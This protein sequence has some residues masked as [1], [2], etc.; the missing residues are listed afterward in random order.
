MSIN[1]ELMKKK[2]AILKGEVKENTSGSIFFTPEEGEQDIRIITPADGDPFKEVFFHYNLPNVPGGLLCPKRN[3]GEDC[4]I[5]EFASQL[6][7]EYLDTNDEQTKQLA[8]DLFVRSRYFS[9]IVVRGKES[10]GI[11]LY[12][13][14]KKAYEM[15]LGYVLDP[16]YGDITDVNEGTDIGL[17]Y[18]KPQKKGAL[19]QTSM[20]V[21]RST[22]P[23]LADKS[24]IKNL[25][26]TMPSID[27]AFAD[28]RKSAREI[29]KILDEMMSSDGSAE[30]RSTETTHY[31]NTQSAVDSAFNDLKS[32]K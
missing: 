29:E 13:Y 7:R 1:L 31:N 26:S 12:G 4:P 27:D 14:G 11:K 9:P 23:L 25:L 8:K 15:L 32:A 19:P 18:T 17:T 2:L 20:K 21:R 6:W 10:D 30:S 5:C 16:E 24:S 22:S 3:S 28:K